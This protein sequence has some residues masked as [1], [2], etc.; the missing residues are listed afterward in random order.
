MR[1]TDFIYRITGIDN[2]GLHQSLLIQQGFLL[3][4]PW[5]ETCDYVMDRRNKMAEGLSTLMLKQLATLI[6]ELED[7]IQFLSMELHPRKIKVERREQNSLTRVQLRQ[8]MISVGAWCHQIRLTGGEQ[9]F[10]LPS[11][12]QSRSRIL[13]KVWDLVRYMEYTLA[14]N[15]SIIV[16]NTNCAPHESNNENGF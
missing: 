2:I 9:Y 13:S 8:S 12:E 1:N 14:Q 15:L 6:S 4:N 5:T 16:R 7:G 11:C 10:N 3:D